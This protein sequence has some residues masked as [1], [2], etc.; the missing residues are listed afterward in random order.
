MFRSSRIKDHH[1]EQRLFTTRAVV[2]IA[3][4]LLGIGAIVARLVWLQVVKYEYFADLAT[5]NRIRLEPLPPNRGLILDRKGV[6]LALNAPSYQLELTREQVPDLEATLRGLANLSL[7]DREDLTRL[8]REI[9]LRRSFEA[10]PVKLQ[11][12]EEELARFAVRQQDFP[13]V[14]IRPRLTRYYP[15][16]ESAV[17]AVGYVG[18]VSEEDQKHIDMDEYTGTTLIGKSGV[19]KKYEDALHG[20]TGFQQLIVNASG[21][22]VEK[23]GSA[24]P[25]LKRREPVAGN[26]LYLTI[27]EKIQAVAE[28]EMRG[29]R[30][31]IVAIN[32][33]NGDVI[34]FVSAPGFDPNLFVRGIS[35]AQYKVLADDID[36]PMYDRALRGTYPSGS[37]IKPFMALTALQYGVITPEGKV[38]CPGYFRLGG[39]GHVWKDWERG[40]GYIDMVHAI[41]RSCDVYFY[42][43]ANLLGVDHIHDFLS[44]FGFGGLTGIDIEG[45]QTALL[46][47]T[48]WKRRAYK[49][50]EMQQWF[51]GD[52]IS[53]GIGQGFLT[54][55]PL[56]LAHGTATIAMHGQ[57]FQPRLVHAVRN[58]VTGKVDE[59]PPVVLKPVEVKDPG[60]W[61]VIVEGMEEVVK[62]GGTAVVA[63][64]G[65]PYRIAAK[66]GTAQAFSLAQGQRYNAAQLD[67]RLHDHAWFEAFAPADDP[68]VAIAIVVENGGHGGSAA[69]P[70]ARRIFDMLLLTPEQLA[71]QE[72][73][74]AALLERQKKA[75]AANAAKPNPPAQEAPGVEE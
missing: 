75:A 44:E 67:E 23:L 8:K 20:K 74:R 40:H 28:E 71:E 16:A 1:A 42:T 59:L 61:D 26:D 43:M 38:F 12:N 63:S 32:P 55:T 10:V 46:P 5:G 62:P 14:E 2:A 39:A 69:A 31:A 70:I 45:E 37:T 15:L 18:A 60:Y 30:G 6:P 48:D 11:L 52:T 56:Q 25:D 21:R 35:R 66:T 36:Q 49:R 58:S 19:E 72:A 50:K 24:T 29:K 9:I 17:H 53:I 27:D 65:A 54:V 7:L 34:A 22:R 13:G 64:A 73:K 33:K 41:K 47:S 68:Q 51:P 4:M 57:R 3:I